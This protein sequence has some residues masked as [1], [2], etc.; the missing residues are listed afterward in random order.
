MVKKSPVAL[1]FRY[2]NFRKAPVL[3]FWSHIPKPDRVHDHH[4]N[5]GDGCYGQCAGD[6]D[7]SEN[8]PSA[9]IFRRHVHH[10]SSIHKKE[11]Y[12][13]NSEHEESNILDDELVDVTLQGRALLKEQ[14]RY[15]HDDGNDCGRHCCKYSE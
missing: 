11:E 10:I 1:F 12:R 7:T 4:D 14:D 8:M 3:G 9:N 13:K 2:L 15:R 6:H 5:G